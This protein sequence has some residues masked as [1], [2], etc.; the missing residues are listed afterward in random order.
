M[1]GYN[2]ALLRLILCLNML[3]ESE[4]VCPGICTLR[5]ILL[6]KNKDLYIH[7]PFFPEIKKD[8]LLSQ[9]SLTRN[10]YTIFDEK[11]I[12][13]IHQHDHNSSIQFQTLLFTFLSEDEKGKNYL[14][15]IR[16]TG[17]NRTL[18]HAIADIL[19]LISSIM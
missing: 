7:V 13:T 9:Q 8:R 12:S 11:Q 5:D 2:I 4:R 14:R 3:P 19:W 1:N 16:L 18:S 17:D 6:N 10:I 15:S